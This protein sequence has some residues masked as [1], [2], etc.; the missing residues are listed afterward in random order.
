MFA[1]MLW[2]TGTAHAQQAVK[3]DYEYLVTLYRDVCVST[4]PDFS[5]VSAKLTKR[6]FKPT[7]DGNWINERVFFNITDGTEKDEEPLCYC[8]LRMPSTTRA[9]ADVFQ[10]RLAEFDVKYIKVI[11]KGVNLT[12]KISRNG[13]NG[14]MRS[15][16][17]GPT[18]A[19]NIMVTQ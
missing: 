12:A 15:H 17:L 16:P 19:L 8:N 1:I 13:T 7:S 6:G 14:I 5:R 4:F 2:N 9:L 3:A 18:A 10:E 11:R